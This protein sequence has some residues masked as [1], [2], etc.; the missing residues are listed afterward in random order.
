MKHERLDVDRHAADDG[1]NVKLWLKSFQIFLEAPQEVRQAE[2][3]RSLITRMTD[4]PKLI[5]TPLSPSNLRIR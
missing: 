3:E 1:Q 4:L 5:L 2:T